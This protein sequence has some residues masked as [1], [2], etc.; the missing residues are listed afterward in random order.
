MRDATW[1]YAVMKGFYETTGDEAY[2]EY[3]VQ[4]ESEKYLK[5]WIPPV[6][7]GSINDLRL[8]L[9]SNAPAW[10]R[11]WLGHSDSKYGGW[12]AEFWRD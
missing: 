1:I 4:E 11:F 2:A 7:R 10:F 6:K 3:V 12:E 5:I 8:I 9:S